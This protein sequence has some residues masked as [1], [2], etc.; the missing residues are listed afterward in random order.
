METVG[1]PEVT[2]TYLLRF[3]AGSRTGLHA[4]CDLSGG[5]AVFVSRG[6][7]PTSAVVLFAEDLEG[8]SQRTT[9][10]WLEHEGGEW[11]VRAFN[12]GLSRILG[13][14][15]EQLWEAARQ[16]RARGNDFNAA[17]LYFA[18]KGT[19]ER[20]PF[21]Q[22]RMFQDF[23]ADYRTFVAPETIRGE[24]PYTWTFDGDTFTV[25]RLHYMGFGSGDVGLI[26]DHSPAAW[27]E[28]AE[29][30]AINHRLIDGFRGAF[31]EWREAF[32]AVIARAAKPGTNQTWGTV[33]T[34]ANGYSDEPDADAER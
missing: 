5:R 9:S 17:M 4:P 3:L 2:E 28:S 29:A 18:A 14:D 13:K 30:S 16:Q 19:A 31:P 24:G 11:R 20:G 7:T 10:V 8:A 23:N 34:A 21:Y 15:S 27:T 6:S 22:A 25:T 33:Y 26:I 1:P 12:F 32:D